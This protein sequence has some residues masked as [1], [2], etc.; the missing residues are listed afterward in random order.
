MAICTDSALYPCSGNS[1]PSFVAEHFLVFR[2][3][4]ILALLIQHSHQAIHSPQRVGCSGPSFFSNSATVSLCSLLPLRACLDLRA[5]RQ[6]VHTHQCVWMLR[7]KCLL[8]Q[9]QNLFELSFHLFVLFFFG[10][11]ALYVVRCVQGP[12][13][14]PVYL[15]RRPGYRCWIH[16][17]K[18]IACILC[19]FLPV[20]VATAALSV[21]TAA[22]ERTWEAVETVAATNRYGLRF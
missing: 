11:S 18:R 4:L 16:H 6:A 10:F 17:N 19:L 2:L 22:E 5:K 15:C 14:Y 20:R 1:T 3:C 9:P 21:Q 8:E 7:S 12:S 13:L